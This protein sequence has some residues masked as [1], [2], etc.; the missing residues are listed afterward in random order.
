MGSAVSYYDSLVEIPEMMNNDQEES[1]GVN[2]ISRVSFQELP[3]KT[4]LF[5]TQSPISSL[6]HLSPPS[7]SNKVLLQPIQNPF[8]L[9]ASFVQNDSAPP[10]QQPIRRYKFSSS[11]RSTMKENTDKC[12]FEQ[13]NK[14]NQKKIQLPP[15]DMNEIPS[16]VVEVPNIELT[17]PPINVNNNLPTVQIPLP[18]KSEE[19]DS[20]LD[21]STN[22]QSTVSNGFTVDDNYLKRRKLDEYIHMK[23]CNASEEM[24]RLRQFQFP[25]SNK[26]VMQ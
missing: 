17:L 9:K 15:I 18:S 19:I 23:Q 1:T 7:P 22:H 4:P 12:P 14:R 16:V 20:K 21:E 10:A 5:E 11:P 2:S 13:E 6:K 25:I 26:L 3:P 24:F 8:P